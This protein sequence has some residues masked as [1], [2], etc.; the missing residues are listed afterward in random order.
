[1]RIVALSDT[2]FR[3]R[4]V[5]VPDGDVVIHAGDLTRS[6]DPAELADVMRWFARL[7]HPHKIFIAGNHDWVFELQPDIAA[8]LIPE[9]VTY[10]QDSGSVIEGVKFWGSPVQPAFLRWAFNRTRGEEIDR[11]WQ[12]IPM[13]TDVL[14]TH[15]PPHGILDLVGN[16]HV[17]CEMLRRRIEIVRPACHVFGHIHG[18]RGTGTLGSTMLI[19][20]AICTENYRP[21]N[22]P[23]VLD[24]HDGIVAIHSGAEHFP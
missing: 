14:I 11:H 17:G 13:G 3:H 23:F 8:G 12:K 10:L 24:L 19:N 21:I 5:A 2:H 20:A 22:P 6:G 4:C 18:A 7:P 16:E 15:G 1:M 9:G